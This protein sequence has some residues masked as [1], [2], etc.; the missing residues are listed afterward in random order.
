MAAAMASSSL[1]VHLNCNYSLRSF[2]IP[3]SSGSLVK[4]SFGF[5]SKRFY[6]IPKERYAYLKF[7]FSH[8]LSEAEIL[9]FNPFGSFLVVWI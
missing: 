9:P 5:G 2:A 4:G 8:L 3:S 1:A 7:Y 6:I